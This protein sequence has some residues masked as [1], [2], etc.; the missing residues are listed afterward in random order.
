MAQLGIRSKLA[1]L[2]SCLNMK[3]LKKRKSNERSAIDLDEQGETTDQM[4]PSIFYSLG[5]ATVLPPPNP[6]SSQ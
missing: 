5:P 1:T 6:K 2:L 3:S 4:D